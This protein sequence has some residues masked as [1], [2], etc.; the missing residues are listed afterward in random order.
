M[1]Q[2]VQGVLI[3]VARALEGGCRILSLNQFCV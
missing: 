1:G 2:G 3:D